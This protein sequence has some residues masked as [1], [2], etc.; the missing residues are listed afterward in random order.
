MEVACEVADEFRLLPSLAGSFE[1]TTPFLQGISCFALL[2]FTF[3]ICRI[4][5]AP[6]RHGPHAAPRLNPLPNFEPSFLR[7]P[8]LIGEC[9]V[10]AALPKLIFRLCRAVLRGPITPVLLYSE[11]AADWRCIFLGKMGEGAKFGGDRSSLDREISQEWTL[12]CSRW[13]GEWQLVRACG[14]AKRGI[15]D[16]HPSS[17]RVWIAN[18]PLW[19]H[20]QV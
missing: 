17:C 15:A 13:G 5:L 8:F 20:L 1:R 6:G 4:R 19:L 7:L 14:G 10:K 16:L 9:T 3:G 2:L 11:R 18:A 12:N